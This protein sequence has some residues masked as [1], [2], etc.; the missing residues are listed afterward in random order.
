MNPTKVPKYLVITKESLLNGD[1]SKNL[2]DKNQFGIFT[3]SKDFSL[4]ENVRFSHKSKWINSFVTQ[5]DHIGNCLTL[6]IASE[7]KHIDIVLDFVGMQKVKK[8]LILSDKE[9]SAKENPRK[10]AL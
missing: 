2:I 3:T 9:K 8:S 5:L 6:W 1:F 10:L 7:N 4:G